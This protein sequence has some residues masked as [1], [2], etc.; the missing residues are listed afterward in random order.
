[1]TEARGRVY[2][3]G[4]H[5]RGSL[6][7]P[8]AAWVPYLVDGK[9]RSLLRWLNVAARD[10]R[11]PGV[12]VYD[13]IEHSGTI[14]SVKASKLQEV[15]EADFSEEQRRRLERM[16]GEPGLWFALTDNAPWLV[17]PEWEWDVIVRLM[18]E[19]KTLGE[20][21]QRIGG[22][23]QELALWI[24]WHECHGALKPA[25]A[26]D[27]HAL[28]CGCETAEC[29][30]TKLRE[31]DRAQYVGAL[32]TLSAWARIGLLI[33]SGL[34][35]RRER[36]G[37]AATPPP[38]LDDLLAEE[39][40]CAV[41]QYLSRTRK[42]LG[43]EMGRQISRREFAD[44]VMPTRTEERNRDPDNVVRR[45]RVWRS[46]QETPCSANIRA[47]AGRLGET[48]AFTTDIQEEVAWAGHLAVAVDNLEARVPE[49]YRSLMAE[50]VRRQRPG[51]G[52][53]LPER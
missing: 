18:Q 27:L 5:G 53:W 33:E 4:L 13:K 30:E 48:Y 22:G 24:E 7:L 47:L 11:T 23:D 14:Q 3:P 28:L 44:S 39:R 10:P 38:L 52:R 6:V 31:S 36:R 9:K 41:G 15:Y 20:R 25:E 35:L 2:L 29:R 42:W 37:D 17:D 45:E 8:P 19:E 43:N 34:E 12:T 26:K 16:D 46:G 1:M 32:I 49:H 51:I 40:D 50:A 21:R